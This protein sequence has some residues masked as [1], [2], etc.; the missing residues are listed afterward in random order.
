MLKVL[1]R[2]PA[3]LLADAV[4]QNGRQMW[5]A[6]NKKA[7]HEGRPGDGETKFNSHMAL[8]LVLWRTKKHD[9]QTGSSENLN[10]SNMPARLAYCCLEATDVVLRPGDGDLH[11]F[12]RPPWSVFGA[13]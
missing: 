2:R 5:G 10:T 6:A 1:P 13:G 9:S 11:G 12:R 3:L 7:C 4:G 8:H